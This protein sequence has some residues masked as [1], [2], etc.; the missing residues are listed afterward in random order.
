MGNLRLNS[1]QSTAG[2]PSHVR[3]HR[4]L[5]E[6]S[7]N[8]GNHLQFNAAQFG[9]KKPEN[10]VFY[11][12]ITSSFMPENRENLKHE[13]ESFYALNVIL[14]LNLQAGFAENFSKILRYPDCCHTIT[15]L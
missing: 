12:R 9:K 4:E 10:D 13:M 2:K 3:L 5:A 7:I 8:T 11:D 14:L 6:K 15:P 1:S